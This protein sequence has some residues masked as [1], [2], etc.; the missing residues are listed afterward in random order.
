[1]TKSDIPTLD[2]FLNAPPDDEG[3]DQTYDPPPFTIREGIARMVLDGSALDF[4]L[5]RGAASSS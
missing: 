4:D 3:Q 2:D 5:R 1:M